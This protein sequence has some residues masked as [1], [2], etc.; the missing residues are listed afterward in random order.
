GIAQAL[1]SAGVPVT[2]F[3]QFSENAEKALDRIRQSLQRRVASGKL[4]AD[5]AEAA[6]GRITLADNFDAIGEADLVIES[7]FELLEIK[8]EVLRRIESV[9]R[10]DAIV[11]SNTSTLS[12]DALAAAMRLPDRLVGMHFFNP[13]HS[14]PLVE[15][16]RRPSTPDPVVATAVQF[17]KR[18]RKTPVLVNNREGFLVNRVFVPYLVE[19]FALLE[20]GAAARQIDA[21][22]VGF[23]F[24]MG[25][26]T[27]SDMTGIDIVVH[28]HRELHKAFPCHGPLSAV[29]HHLVALHRT[30]QKSGA[31]VYRYL[32]GDKTALD[33]PKLDEIV[34]QVQRAGGTRPFD[35]HQITRRLVGRMIAEAFRVL[36]ENV[37]RSPADLDA[38]MILGTGMPD[39]RGGIVRYAR[40]CGLDTVLADLENLSKCCSERYA[41]GNHLRNL[42]QLARQG[43][44][45][46]F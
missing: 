40:D 5:K 45:P 31:G 18:L 39:Y 7:V 44:P 4:A 30:G 23:G 33:D 42:V 25:P 46:P 21:A 11:A 38:A 41:P 16:I 22:M 27:L 43:Q 29:A 13:A 15:V 1:A 20:E 9:C 17:A 3:D 8:Q 26:L 28:A 10:D 37:A 14:M 6:L 19:A 32:P 35:D 36:E 12:L 34:A 24:P 2:V